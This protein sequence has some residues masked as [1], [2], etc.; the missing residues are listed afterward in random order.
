VDGGRD[1]SVYTQVFDYN[2]LGRLTGNWATV[3]GALPVKYRKALSGAI[4]TYYRA[5]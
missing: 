1:D 3:A 2:G 5:A 4:N